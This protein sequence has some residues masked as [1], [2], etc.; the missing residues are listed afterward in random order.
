M[1][2]HVRTVS[3]ILA[4]GAVLAL[5]LLVTPAAVAEP[6]AP[7]RGLATADRLETQV[8][9]EINAFRTARRL[10]P[11]RLSGALAASAEHH[12]LDMVVDGFFGHDTQGSSYVGRVRSH[13]R[14]EG[15]RIWAVGENLLWASPT[16]SPRRALWLWLRSPTHRANL[17]DPR[18]REVGLAAVHASTA[19]G[20]FRGLEVT[21]LTVD[22]GVRR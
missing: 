7:P 4:A 8:L 2:E 18:W 21:V 3:R 15:Y 22:F 14:S 16:V 12:S 17:L 1:S 6:D 5:G 10:R 11:L 19:P 13:Y 9:R 20:Y